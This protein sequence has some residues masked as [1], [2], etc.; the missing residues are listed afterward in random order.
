MSKSGVQGGRR[1]ST[2]MK[3]SAESKGIVTKKTDVS[4]EERMTTGRSAKQSE[5][6]QGRTL[7]K[8]SK[9]LKKTSA[10]L[11]RRRKK[12]PPREIG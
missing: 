4:G 12:M 10:S 2:S 7:V 8:V 11:G 9:Q 6:G 3:K 5:R 1:R